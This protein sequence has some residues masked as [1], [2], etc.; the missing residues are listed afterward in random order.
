LRRVAGPGVETAAAADRST[1]TNIPGLTV[2]QAAATLGLMHRPVFESLPSFPVV[3]PADPSAPAL[4]RALALAGFRL[5]GCG[6]TYEG[7][8][9]EQETLAALRWEGENREEGAAG[10]WSVTARAEPV[11]DGA[12]IRFVFRCNQNQETP[13]AVGLAVD[14]ATWSRSTYVLMPGAV[15]GGNRLEV[16]P[17]NYS[18][19]Y[20]AADARPGAPAVMTDLPRLEHGPGDSGLQLLTGDLA[21]PVLGLW[22]P[23]RR[24]GWLLVL[25]ETS[26]GPDA[27]WELVE[28]KARDR[29][30]FRLLVPGVRAARYSFHGG[31]IRTDAPSDDRG[32]CFRAGEQVEM[33]VL[34]LHFAAPA[35]AT[36]YDRLLTVLSQRE[37]WT[38]I[39]ASREEIPISAAA[40]LVAEKRIRDDWREELGVL[41][42]TD[43]RAADYPFQTGWCG[44]IIAESALLA[45]GGEAAARGRQSLETIVR[46]GQRPSGLFF[47]KLQRDGT[48]SDDFALDAARPH[49]QRWT[50]VR[51]Q[52]DALWYLQAAIDRQQALAEPVPP[53]W[54][55]AVRRLA[56][57]L[58]QLWQTEGQLGQFID[59]GE[60]RVRVGGSTSGALVPAGLSVAARRFAQPEWLQ[61][62]AKIGEHFWANATA[63]GMTTGGPADALQ[64][65][66][67]ESAAGLVES[68]LA[69]FE[70]GEGAVWLDRARAAAAQLASWVMPY[71]FPFPEQSE[72][73]RLGMPSAGSVFA[74]VQN[75][76]AAPGLCTHS[77]LALLR[78]YRHTQDERLLRLLADL[79]RFIP[80]TVSRADRPIRAADGRILPAGWINERVNTSDWDHN[81]GGV[82][83]GSTWSEVA[84][85]L[86]AVELP[87]V[88]VRTDT[89]TVTC[90]DHVRARL[91]DRGRLQLE[92]PTRY[93]AEVRWLAESDEQAR[94][95]PLG[96]A[97]VLALPRVTIGPR[98]HR[99]V[100][101]G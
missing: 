55:D 32:R 86:T 68:Y 96:V 65:P 39:H 91:D 10:P 26:R 95:R 46:R 45:L 38:R 61:V 40:G 27:L 4:V 44:G 17:Q 42:T 60:A 76:H 3:S 12:D 52:A 70:A 30:Q 31:G 74:N 2:S 54:R 34:L 14:F 88:Y 75:K 79:A 97:T 71:D 24:E 98:E 78:V 73:G 99:V 69:L 37:P 101:L 66:D 89:G 49:T 43:N 33:R 50:L 67:S 64:C 62:A 48:W 18:P 81:G 92:N 28:A 56:Q 51:R 11:E 82:F 94:T 85:L 15:Y 53:D 77:G 84:L 5:A 93:P 72:F 87:G 7:A 63:M 21:S 100:E 6:R 57:A 23:E 9:L 1:L 59:T 22:W 25:R 19:R 41:A 16:R 58:V 83:H 35:L 29:A 90:L 13:A 36:L 47:G 8:R 80:W 20:A